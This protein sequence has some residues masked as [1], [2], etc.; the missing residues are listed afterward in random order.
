MKRYGLDIVD[1]LP[2]DDKITA[3]DIREACQEMVTQMVVRWHQ[4]FSA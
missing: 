3:E 1:A 2:P 4:V